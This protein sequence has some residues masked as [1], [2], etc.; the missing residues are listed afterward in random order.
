MN[1]ENEGGLRF[2]TY[3]ENESGL[4][5]EFVAR[6]AQPFQG[7][8]SPWVGGKQKLGEKKRLGDLERRL[9]V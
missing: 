1:P 4:R 6:V 7:G 2:E 5:F 9:G 3:P 8:G